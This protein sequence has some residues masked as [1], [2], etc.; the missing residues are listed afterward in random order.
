MLN[1]LASE[2]A[3]KDALA[4][5]LGRGWQERSP[6]S[7]RW[8]LE[9]P[10]QPG[11]FTHP[12]HKENLM[13]HAAPSSGL[14]ELDLDDLPLPVIHDLAGALRYDFNCDTADEIA[15]REELYDRMFGDEAPSF[16]R[17]IDFRW[18]AD[19]GTI[20]RYV[21]RIDTLDDSLAQVDGDS[22]QS[23]IALLKLRSDVAVKLF[24]SLP[25]RSGSLE[26]SNLYAYPGDQYETLARKEKQAHLLSKMRM[27][28]AESQAGS[29]S[30]HFSDVQ[31]AF[32]KVI[33]ESSKLVS[34]R[35]AEAV[36]AAFEDEAQ[37][38][39]MRT[40]VLRKGA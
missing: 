17:A 40:S 16:P 24:C 12:A 29:F 19:H 26:V 15:C 10:A 38:P 37:A 6:V 9:S 1:A 11:F 5:E 18:T 20:S 33:S 27:L 13:F 21:E 39:R 8:H 31:D 35:D 7:S 14:V 32:E 36:K 28:V 3:F 25:V 23:F 4:S 30:L 34:E 2:L 22:D